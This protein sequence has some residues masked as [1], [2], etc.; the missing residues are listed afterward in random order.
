MTGRSGT[1]V[2]KMAR[3][4]LFGDAL[5]FSMDDCK[6]ALI[7]ESTIPNNAKLSQVTQVLN[8]ENITGWTV[9]QYIPPVINQFPY[10]GEILP[11]VTMSDYSIVFTNSSGGAVTFSTVA[12]VI[13]NSGDYDILMWEVL[14]APVTLANGDS[15]TVTDL[16]FKIIET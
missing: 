7:L 1:F 13:S 15:F 9:Q 14:D 3:R 5:G 2:A 4:A 16:T 8:L 6:L 12:V 10:Q 11:Q